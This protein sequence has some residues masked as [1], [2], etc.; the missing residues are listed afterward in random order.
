MYSQELVKMKSLIATLI[1]T[2][3][4]FL[5]FQVCIFGFAI[6]DYFILCL[7]P[8]ATFIYHVQLVFRLKV[9]RANYDILVRSDSKYYQFFKGKFLSVISSF[10]FS[11]LA[12]VVLSWHFLTASNNELLVLSLSPVLTGA[13]YILS[14]KCFTEHYLPPFDQHH[15]MRISAM[16]TCVLIFL[17]LWFNSFYVE[18]A[19]SRLFQWSLYEAITNTSLTPINDQSFVKPFIDAANAFDV[20]KIWSV[21]QLKYQLPDELFQFLPIALSL[22]TALVSILLPRVAVFMIYFIETEVM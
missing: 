6:S 5:T 12:I 16:V 3:F 20:L 2:L 4:I 14:K 22:D 15:A 10:L 18:T 11:I 19:D 1:S 17:I 21:V 13:I 8:L 7:I 9:K